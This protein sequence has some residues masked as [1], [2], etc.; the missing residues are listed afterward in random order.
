[1]QQEIFSM[2]KQQY[3]CDFDNEMLNE[4]FLCKSSHFAERENRHVYLFI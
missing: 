1:M 4:I 2:Q 3:D